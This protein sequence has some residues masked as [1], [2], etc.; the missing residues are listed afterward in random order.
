MKRQGPEKCVQYT[1]PLVVGERNVRVCMCAKGDFLLGGAGTKWMEAG[2]GRR[3]FGVCPF[4]ASR[5]CEGI[6]CSK[7]LI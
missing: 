4:S 7:I 3:C 2:V 6:V 5:S 1:P